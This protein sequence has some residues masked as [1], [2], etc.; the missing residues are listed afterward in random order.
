MHATKSFAIGEGGLIYCA[1]PARI[2]VLRSMAGFGFNDARMAAMPGLNA[3]L[4]EVSALLA[5]TKLREIEP[6]SAARYRLYK[7]YRRLLPGFTFQRMTGRRCGMQFVSLLLPDDGA[8]EVAE[9][10]AGLARHGIGTGRYFSPHLAQH[11]FFKE[12]C[13]AGTLEVT[14]AISR[15][16]IALPMS[17]FLT[18]A[19]VRFICA[20]LLRLC[21]RP[22]VRHLGGPAAVLAHSSP[23]VF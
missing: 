15:R 3:K 17:D 22:E 10:I 20:T 21:R 18:V 12:S 19:E 14:E 2:A 23:A 8:P 13:V 9:V 6:I 16:V 11:P 4:G 1:D 7:L 5:L